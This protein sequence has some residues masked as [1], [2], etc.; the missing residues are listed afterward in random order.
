[1]QEAK[2]QSNPITMYRKPL[3]TTITTQCIIVYR[4]VTHLIGYWSVTIGDVKL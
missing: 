1:M 4:N 3:S 2:D